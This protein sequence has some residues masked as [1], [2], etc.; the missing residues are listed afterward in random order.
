MRTVVKLSVLLL[1]V[2]VL[3]ITLCSPT[4]QAAMNSEQVV[5]SGTG[6]GVFPSAPGHS[7]PFGFWVWCESDSTNP[8]VGAC[9]GAMY[10]YALGLTRHVSG[11]ITELSSGAYLMTVHSSDGAIV[12]SLTNTPPVTKGPTNIVTAAFSSPAGAGKSTN[13]VVNVT[14]P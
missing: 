14:G 2:M 3:P 9:A 11:T 6:S 12:A 4:V 7:S 8:Y 1:L 10:V 13:A 5:F